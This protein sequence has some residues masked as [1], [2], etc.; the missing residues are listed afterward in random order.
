[1]TNV[2]KNKL[3]ICR[4]I[5]FFASRRIFEFYSFLSRYKYSRGT[6]LTKMSI[7]KAAKRL[8]SNVYTKPDVTDRWEMSSAYIDLQDMIGTGAFGQVFCAEIETC[9][10]S[11]MYKQ[12][13]CNSKQKTFPQE[14]RV[15]KVAVKVLKGDL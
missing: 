11:L 3:S 1:M 4:T 13:I 7:R 12:S 2:N 6:S 8:K 14:K 5:Y 15:I 9:K 10:M